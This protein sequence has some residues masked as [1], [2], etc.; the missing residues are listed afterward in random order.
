MADPT[1]QTLARLAAD[2][3]FGV[4]RV[5]VTATFPLAQVDEAF[6]AFGAGTLGKVAITCA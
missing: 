6:A 4:L 3:A 1:S 2:A 5:P